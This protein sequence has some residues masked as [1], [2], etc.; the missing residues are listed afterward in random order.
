MSIG[1]RFTLLA[2]STTWLY[3]SF[4]CPVFK[5]KLC[6]VNPSRFLHSTTKG[7]LELTGGIISPATLWSL[8]QCNPPDAGTRENLPPHHLDN[9]FAIFSSYAFPFC[10]LLRPTCF[11]PPYSS[12]VR[13]IFSYRHPLLPFYFNS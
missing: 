10:L 9:S 5:N 12:K 11:T 2:S 8:P 6:N 13:V 4:I 3:H 1:V 7:K